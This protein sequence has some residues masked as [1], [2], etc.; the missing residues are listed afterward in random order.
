MHQQQYWSI[1]NCRWF[2][3]VRRAQTLHQAM[4]IKSFRSQK[5]VLQHR[6]AQAQQT[7]RKRRQHQRSQRQQRPKQMRMR[8][9][10]CEAMYVTVKIVNKSKTMATQ[11]TIRINRKPMRKRTTMVWLLAAA[12]A[13]VAA[14]QPASMPPCEM[15]RTRVAVKPETITSM[16]RRNVSVVAD[17]NSQVIHRSGTLTE[18]FC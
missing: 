14:A 10:K 5:R 11:H 8:Q 18:Q 3:T 17:Q 2:Q 7:H 6:L 1:S 16:L 12:A 15:R 4:P 9:R 13:A